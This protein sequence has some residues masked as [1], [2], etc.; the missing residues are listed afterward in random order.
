V[1][2]ITG[3]F[4]EARRSP[5]HHAAG[6]GPELA[7]AARLPRKVARRTGS[8]ESPL[9][10]R[11]TLKEPSEVEATVVGRRGDVEHLILSA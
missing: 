1:T 3:R 9:R 2:D 6:S 7:S 5:R 11:I 8:G 10:K 4:A